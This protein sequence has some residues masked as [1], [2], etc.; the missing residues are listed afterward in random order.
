MSSSTKWPG[1]LCFQS[2]LVFVCECM[3]PE[4]KLLP[5]YLEY[6]LT[7]FDQ[8]FITN[9]LSGKDEHVK[10]WG[11]KVRGHGHCGVKYAQSCTFW[12]CSCHILADA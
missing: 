11:Q 10:F 3:S 6:L 2:V 5:R 12:L 9:E 7:E 1:A 4:Q 8:T